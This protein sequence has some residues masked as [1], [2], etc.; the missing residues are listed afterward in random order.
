MRLMSRVCAFA[1]LVLAISLLVAGSAQA[2]PSLQLGPGT[3][4]WTYDTTTQTWVT[5][6]N[7]LQLAATANATTAD[8]GNGAYAWDTL[9]T[10]QLAYL[11]VSVIPMTALSEPPDIFDITVGNDA[12]TLSLLASGNG[13][14]PLNDPNDLAPHGIF[15]TYFEI[16]EFNFDGAL[17][18]ISDT[19]PGGSGSGMGYLELFDITVNSLAPSVERLHFDLFTV[20]GAS[21]WDPNGPVD[22]RL[23]E[24]FAPFSHDAE[25]VPEPSGALLFGVGALIAATA[26]GRRR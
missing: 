9:G 22:Q 23:V 1:S 2:I 6:D 14:P 26:V 12:G 10:S 21:G 15:D 8:G 4:S 25:V 5:T 19:Q 7:P 16:Y 17:V 3:G 24:A 18:G 11:V 13:A 20:Q